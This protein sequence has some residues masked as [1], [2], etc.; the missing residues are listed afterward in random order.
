MGTSAVSELTA[1]FRCS[2]AG[3]GAGCPGG[4]VLSDRTRRL[5]GGWRSARWSCQRTPTNILNERQR[6]LTPVVRWSSTV[7][8]TEHE[9][10]SVVLPTEP[11]GLVSPVVP[12]ESQRSRDC[13][14][15]ARL[16]RGR[17]GRIAWDASLA[18]L[19]AHH[20]AGISRA[21]ASGAVFTTVPT[22]F[23]VR[24]QGVV[25]RTSPRAS[26]VVKHLLGQLDSG[27]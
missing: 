23:L 15:S 20:P 26:S 4:G 14:P 17:T 16:W 22:I 7:L 27:A 13:A 8:S 2:G 5:A 21:L 18:V 25:C 9:R 6:I 11:R 3:M 10:T 1:T 24:R 12:R 19:A